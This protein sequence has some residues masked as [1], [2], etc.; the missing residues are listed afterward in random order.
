MV[1]QGELLNGLSRYYVGVIVR[2]LQ[3]GHRFKRVDT[4]YVLLH[5]YL[6]SQEPG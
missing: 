1:E 3:M 6:P 5:Q 2:S 4:G